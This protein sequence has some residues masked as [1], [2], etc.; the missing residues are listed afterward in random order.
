M[1]RIPQILGLTL[2]VDIILFDQLSKWWITEYFIRPL[3]DG[4]PI[5]LGEWIMDAPDRLSAGISTAIMPYFNLTMVWNEGVSF[6][7]L[8]NAGIWPL[9]IMATVISAFLFHWMMKST[10]KFEAVSLGMIIGGAIG[11]TIDRFR[12]GAVADFFDV[13]MGTYHW[14]AFNIADAAIS[15]GVVL[16]LIYGVFLDTEGKEKMNKLLLVSCAVVGLSAC[17][18]SAK[19]NLGLVNV[20]PDE[21]SVVTRAPLSV[22]PDYTLRPPRPGVGRPMEISTQEQARQ[23]IFGVSDVTDAGKVTADTQSAGGFLS[24]VGAESAN[25][26]IRDV[27]DTETPTDNRTT[28]ERLLFLK[29]KTDAEGDPIDPNAEFERLKSEGVVTIKKRNEEIP[30]P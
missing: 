12:F 3:I 27:I 23:T 2:I 4:T 26:N 17:S 30:A 11:N 7:M 24:K 22:P 13:Y 20:A 25:P 1:N 9:A 8:Q 6:G 18:D 5:G 10:S 15:I 29:G 16:L 14:P 19:E 21:F 28:A